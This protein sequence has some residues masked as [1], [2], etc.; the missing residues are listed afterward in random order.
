MIKESAWRVPLGDQGSYCTENPLRR[1]TQASKLGHPTLCIGPRKRVGLCRK[2]TEVEGG[3]VAEE[4]T[5]SGPPLKLEKKGGRLRRGGPPGGARGRGLSV[6]VATA[7]RKP[8]IADGSYKMD[9][10]S[11]TPELGLGEKVMR[12][13]AVGTGPSMELLPFPATL[14]SSVAEAALEQLLL[15]EKSLQ[16]DYFK[17]NEEARIFLK[18]IA[19]AVKK[20]EEMRKTTVDLLEI[21]SMELSRLYFLLQTLPENMTRELEECIKDARRLNISEINR[22]KMRILTM[23]DK[24]KFLNKRIVELK[25][26][27]ETLGEQQEAVAKQHEEL[28]LLFNQ[29]VEAKAAAAIYISETCTRIELDREETELQKRCV[30]E[31]EEL[32]AK[33]R[34]EYLLRKQ[35]L[36]MQDQGVQ[37]EHLLV[38]AASAEWTSKRSSLQS[39]WL[40]PRPKERCSKA[41]NFVWMIEKLHKVHLENKELREKVNDTAVQYKVVLSEEEKVFLQKQK[42]HEENKKQMA[43]VAQKEIFLTQ[44]QVD[45]KNMEEGLTTLQDLYQATKEVY[46]RQIQI[47]NDNLERERQRC[48]LTQWKILCLKKGHARWLDQIKVDTQEILNKIEYSENRRNELFQETKFREKEINE[49]VVQIQKLTEDIKEEEK[50]LVTKEKVL[51]DHLTKYEELIAKETEISKEKEEQLNEGLPQLHVVEEV[52]KQKHAAIHELHMTLKAQKQEEALMNWNIFQITRDFSRFTDNAVKVKEDLKQLR[53]QEIQATQYHFDTLK[54]LEN[55]IYLYDQKTDLLLL[56]NE[57]LREETGSPDGTVMS[58][59]Q[60][61]AQRRDPYVFAE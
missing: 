29:A 50:K 1:P 47:L 13:V 21:E 38:P 32:M 54:K 45:I 31:G 33:Q 8:G 12:K 6:A 53:D 10:R 52:Y 48:I 55:E 26:R 40:E 24:A 61:L 17:C 44:R 18:D 42:L 39:A 11:G 60:L 49:F 5:L 35:Q 14:G 30:Q 3:R 28:V 27:N 57:K 56:E 22:M 51:I 9:P 58:I 2:D 7:P 46:R 23:D 41:S 25:E 20:L 19:T 37:I 15:V 59:G 16:S 34:A 4:D 36:A 43:F